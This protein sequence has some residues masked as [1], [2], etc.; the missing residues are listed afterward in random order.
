MYTCIILDKKNKNIFEKI[1]DSYYLY[2]LFIN[3]IRKSKKLELVAIIENWFN[4]YKYR[5]EKR[6]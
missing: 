6:I 2:E 3:K 4:N 5:I 1:F